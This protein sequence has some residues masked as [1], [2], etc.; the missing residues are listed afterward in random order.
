METIVRRAH[1]A[2]ATDI[3]RLGRVTFEQ[4][5]GALFRDHDADL[6][7]Y[8]D[9]TF[10]DAKIEASIGKPYNAYW[11]AEQNNVPVGYAKLKDATPLPGHDG[12]AA[13]QLQKIY[14]LADRI[15]HGIGYALLAPVLAHA[16][17]RAPLLWLDVLRENERAIAFYARFGFAPVG[18]DTYTIGAQH[19]R[20]HLMARRSA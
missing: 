12:E 2:D 13:C 11:I 7:T 15:G 14:V 17:P 5:F 8:L 18:D 20:F 10:G 6:R 1:A 3:A 4:S 16:A 9:R 19:F